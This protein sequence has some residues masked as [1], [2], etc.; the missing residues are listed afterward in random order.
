MR[1]NAKKTSFTLIEMVVVIVIIA[2]LGALVGPQVMKHVGK[3]EKNTTLAQMRTLKNAILDYRLDIGKIPDSL[4]ALVSNSG[5]GTKWN[6]PYID[7]KTLPKDAWGNEFN[8]Q[9]LS[10]KPYFEITSNGAD[11]QSGGEGDAEDLTTNK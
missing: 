10:E 5:A 3:A 1:T 2:L 8:Y 9:K 6:G 7:A 11:G 4:E